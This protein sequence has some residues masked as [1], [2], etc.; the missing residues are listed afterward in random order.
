MIFN[1]M[2]FN[3]Y[4]NN[5]WGDGVIESL[6]GI[7]FNDLLS[8]VAGQFYIDFPDKIITVLA[9]YIFVWFDKGKN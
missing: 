2:F 8:H 3:G 7:G 5:I 6:L 4:T 1:Y 9:L